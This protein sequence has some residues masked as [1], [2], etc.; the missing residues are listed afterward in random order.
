MVAVA[1]HP[2]EADDLKTSGIHVC[3]SA[4]FDSLLAIPPLAIL[5]LP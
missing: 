4:H 2:G 3:I 1:G 5:P